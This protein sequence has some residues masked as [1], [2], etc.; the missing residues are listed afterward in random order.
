MKQNGGYNFLALILRHLEHRELLT[1]LL[2]PQNFFM[3]RAFKSKAQAPINSS[4]NSGNKKVD[5]NVA[6]SDE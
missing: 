4:I 2:F 6:G 5:L 3:N 1:E